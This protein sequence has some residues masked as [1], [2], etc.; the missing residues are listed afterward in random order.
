MSTILVTFFLIICAVTD[1]RARVIHLWVLI[2][3]AAAG[4]IF[5]AFSGKEALI[6]GAVG[7]LAGLF[8]FFL[9]FAT[10]GAVGE[11]DGLVLMTTGVYLGFLMNLRLLCSALFLSAVVSVGAVV[12]KGW[13]KD[14]E[15]PFMPFLL[16]AF[17]FIKTGDHFGLI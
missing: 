11:G 12:I 17:I 16:A 3:F 9:S 13:K 1:I 4:L 8:L 15:L 6:S 5:A 10:G 14:R 7:A 2:P